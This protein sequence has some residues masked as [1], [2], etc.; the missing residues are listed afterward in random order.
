[1]L[2]VVWLEKNFFFP[3]F[4]KIFKKNENHF[5]KGFIESMSDLFLLISDVYQ[6]S[7]PR[8]MKSDFMI[9]FDA[10]KTESKGKRSTRESTNH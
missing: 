8:G 9:N 6:L 1:M 7:H 5:T 4:E 10:K 3:C 2:N